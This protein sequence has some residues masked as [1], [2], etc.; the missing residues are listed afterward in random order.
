MEGGFVRLHFLMKST[1]TRSAVEALNLGLDRMLVK[2]A[3]VLLAAAR[4]HLPTRRR[5][6]LAKTRKNDTCR[7]W[8]PLFYSRTKVPQRARSGALSGLSDRNLPSYAH[9]EFL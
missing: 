3:A 1:R 7:R 6:L 4:T 5:R 9:P 2:A 8:L